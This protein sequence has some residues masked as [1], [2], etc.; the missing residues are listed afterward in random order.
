MPR[1]RSP[2]RDKAYEIYKEHNGDIKLKDI[3]AQLNLKDTQIRKW[4]S[5]DKWEQKLKGTLP[6]AKSNVTKSKKNKSNTIKEPIAEEVKELMQ[7][8]ELNDKQRLFCVLYSQTFNATKSYQQA[9]KCTHETAMVNGSKLLSNT[10]IKKQL[11]KLIAPKCNKEYLKR[12]VLQKY[13]DIAF[14]KLDGV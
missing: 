12:G 5:Q 4:K 2:N 8:D 13:I 10:K 14:A 1:E 7:N 6:K 3:A 11:D 9:Y